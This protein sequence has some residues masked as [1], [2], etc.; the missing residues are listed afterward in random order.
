MIHLVINMIIEGQRQLG[1]ITLTP[2]YYQN[3]H[4]S[5]DAGINVYL[6]PAHWQFLFHLWLWRHPVMP[7]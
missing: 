7:V 5:G 6:Q 1:H 2:L 3:Y 4:T